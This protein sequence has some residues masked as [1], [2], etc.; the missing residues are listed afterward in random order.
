MCKKLLSIVIVALLL[1]GACACGD[2]D[3]MTG[4]KPDGS[5]GSPSTNGVVVSFF[6]ELQQNETMPFELTEKAK[7]TLAEKEDMFI[8]NKNDG[9]S[10]MVDSS[11]EYK[12]LTKNIDKHGDKLIYLEEA[13]VLSIDETE[14]DEETTLTEFH[15]LDANENSYYCL[16]LSAYEDIFAE[17]IVGVYALPI[18]E[19]SFENVSG[20]TTLA[21]MLAGCY[22]EKVQ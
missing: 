2:L 18:G 16:S 3:D 9:L 7:K 19:T 5:V 10:G 1:L 20:G 15:L 6:E 11:L 22:I 8:G 17:D 12:V 4:G 21:V 14:L 13:Y